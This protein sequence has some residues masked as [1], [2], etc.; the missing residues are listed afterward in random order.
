[1]RVDVKSFPQE[2]AMEFYQEPRSPRVRDLF[3]KGFAALERGNLDYAIDMLTEA[4]RQEP[5]C[6]QIRKF[7]RAAEIKKFRTLPLSKRLATLVNAVPLY[8]RTLINLQT[9][10][11]EEAF[12][13]AENLLRLN[14]LNGTL[15]MLYTDAAQAAGCEEAAIQTLSMVREH[16]PN[17]LIMIE[18]LGTLQ[19]KAGQARQAREIF[20]F[21]AERKPNDGRILKALKD[22]MALDSMMKDGWA[23]ATGQPEGFRKVI[24][25]EKEAVILEKRDKAVQTTDDTAVLIEDTLRKIQAEPAN[26]NYRRA[27]ANLYAQQK[28]FDKAIETLEEAQ[29]IAGGRDPQ[30]D[31][32]ITQIRLA[33]F[34]HAI[35]QARAAGRNDEA[36]ALEKQR[37][38]FRFE[39]LR[40]RVS[41]YPND[42]V[43]HFEYGMAL[44]ERELWNDAIREF[45]IAQ[46]SPAERVRALFHLGLCFRQ[47]KQFDLAA[48]QIETALA[49]T[50]AM[51]DA[52]KEMMYELALVYEALGQHDKALELFKDIYQVDIG[53]KDVAQRIEKGYTT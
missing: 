21:L 53:F 23:Q 12:R 34:D 44:F 11:S 49:E 25:D 26:L 48:E 7:L 27:L 22:A 20:E 29:K 5:A 52:R 28:E 1:L 42:L 35:E 46:R 41:R 47:K 4:L 37:E 18:R 9:G 51:S 31:A 3:N 39:N 13:T 2:T 32:A 14:P 6:L 16:R 17:D 36:T 40:D 50:P 43:L 38:E 24:R 15:L 33:K 30:V 8:I 45:Q 10:R 19:M